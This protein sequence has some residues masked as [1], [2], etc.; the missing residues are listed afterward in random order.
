MNTYFIRL[1]EVIKRT[2]LSRSTI[3]KSID[4]KTFPESFKISIRAV[5]WLDNDIGEWQESK[6]EKTTK[7]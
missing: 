4:E 1:P 6:I 2:G 3:Y 7:H 5:A